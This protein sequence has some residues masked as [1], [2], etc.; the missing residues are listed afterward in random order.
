[1]YFPFHSNSKKEI[2]E[3]LVNGDFDIE[4][5]R[6]VTF[7]PNFKYLRTYLY[8]PLTEDYNIQTRI[9]AATKFFNAL[10]RSIF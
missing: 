3:E 1:M 6:F 4:G 8:Q 10:G 9:T 5:K 2:L 7:T